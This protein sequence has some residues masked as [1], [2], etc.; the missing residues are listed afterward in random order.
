MTCGDIWEG[1]RLKGS[2]SGLRCRPWPRGLQFA[3]L[4]QPVC[5]ASTNE[6]VCIFAP[7][8]RSILGWL[9]LSIPECRPYGCSDAFGRRRLTIR[10]FCASNIV[11]T[12]NWL[13]FGPVA[14]SDKIH[15]YRI[16]LKCTQREYWQNSRSMTIRWLKGSQKGIIRYCIC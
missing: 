11:W 9:I 7:L 15:Y 16:S 12:W 13:Y 4:V 8:S 2:G 6:S 5:F 14:G 1:L 10:G 3:I